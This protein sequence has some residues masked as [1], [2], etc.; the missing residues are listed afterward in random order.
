MDPYFESEFLE[1]SGGLGPSNYPNL[2]VVTENGS[3]PPRD[4]DE[5]YA[6][7]YFLA[8]IQGEDYA[9]PQFD[10]ESFYVLNSDG[11]AL[12]QSDF[13]LNFQ[14]MTGVWETLQPDNLLDDVVRQNEVGGGYARWLESDAV[15]D[16]RVRWTT[17]R[18]INSSGSGRLRPFIST[19]PSI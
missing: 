1:R 8:K 18:W 5:L 2:S 6:S 3:R 13:L 19:R 14:Y 11:L 7:G 15:F 4:G 9:K 16:Y 10:I 17:R 12:L